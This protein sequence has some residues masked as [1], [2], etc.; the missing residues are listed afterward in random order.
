[1]A[2]NYDLNSINKLDFFS[3]VR[4]YPGMYIGSKDI[5]GLHHLV[6]EAVSNSI[7]E[8][9][10]GSCETI[11][12]IIHK[13]GSI[14]IIDNGRGIPIGK[15]EGSTKTALD[16]C[17]TEEHAGGKF[18]NATG[19]SGY[20][21][22]GGM[23]GLGTK[24]INALSDKMIV[25]SKRDN[26][27]EK[28]VYVKG[29]AKEHTIEKGT[30]HGVA[31][32][33]YPSKDY[34][35]TIEFDASII[36]KMIKEFSFLCKN[37]NFIFTDERTNETVNY[38][39]Q[40]GLYDFIEYLNKDNQFICDPFYFEEQEGTFKIEAAFGYN[41]SY[42]PTVRLFTNNIPQ[43]RG[44]HLTGFK[45]AFTSTFNSFAREKGWLKESDT[46]L[47]GSDLEEGQLLVINFKMIDPVF[48]GQAKEELGSSEG[49]TYV[50]RFTTKALKELFAQREKEVKV[51]FN[52]AIKARKAREE[53][54][55]ARD[56]VRDITSKKD[57][58]KKFL[59]KP[60]KLVDCW[61]KDRLKCQLLI[62]EGDSA[63]NGL[64]DARD[65][66]FHAIIPIRGKIIAAY[67]NNPEKIFANQEVQSLIKA[68]DLEFDMKTQKLIYDTK[69]LRYGK[70]LLCA[71]ADPDGSS[72]RN[73]LIELFWWICPELITKGHLYTTMP[74]LFRITTK[75][76]EYI[77]LKDAAALEDYK[78]KHIGEKY[79]INRNK[80]LGEQDPDELYEA[81]LDEQ[82][83]NIAQLTVEDEQRTALL[84]ETLFG[85]SVPPRRA[86][87]LEHVDDL[88]EYNGLTGDTRDVQNETSDNFIDF[89]NEVNIQRAFADARDGLKPCQRAAL[90]EMYN[91][92][93]TSNKPHVKS[94]R[95]SGGTIAKWWPHS[96]ASI[97]DTFARMSQDWINN[98]PEV[99]WHG[100]NGSVQISGEAAAMRYTEARLSK[101]IEEGMLASINK[102][103]VPMVP[104]FDETAEWPEVFPAILPRLMINGCQG[105]G[106]T[107]ANVWL[108]HNFAEMADIIKTYINEGTIDYSAIAPDFPTGG[109]I[110]NQKDLPTIYQTG[111]G[112]V[113]LRGVA[114]IE[115]NKII[116]TELPYQVYVESF[117]ASVKELVTKEEIT[118]ISEIENRK[119]RS[120][121]K[122]V[123]KSIRIEI[124]CDESPAS[125]LKQ[126]YK[127]TDLQKIYSPNQIAL[128]GKTPTMLNLKQYLDIYI[129]HNYDCIKREYEF[130]RIKAKTRLEIVEGLLRALEDIDNIIALIKA[131]SSSADAAK[132]L[133]AKYDFTEAQA[134]AIVDMKLGRLANLE[135]IE[136]NKE[137]EDLINTITECDD[138]ITQD[139]R[140]SMIFMERLSNLVKK[141]GSSP[142]KTQLTHI[143]VKPEEKEIVN[144]IP[145]DVVVVATQT[146]FIKRVASSA[147][148]VQKRGGKGVKSKDDSLLDVIKTNTVDTIM[149]FTTKGKMYRCSV[150]DI[151]AA[152][153]AAKGTLM[154]TIINLEKDEKVIAITSL[155]RTSTPEFIIF[156]TKNGMIKKSYLSEYTAMKR[157]TGIAALKVK[158][159]DEV[160]K[161]IFQDK[162]DI[163]LISQK[164]MSI[165]FKTDNIAPIGRLTMGVKG[166][167]LA[168]NDYVVAAMSVHKETDQVAV[169]STK[170]YGKK[171][172]L[173]EITSQNR[174]GR[175]LIVY[176]PT[177][178][179]GNVV[180]AAMVSDEDLILLCGN[181]TTICFPAKE[182]SLLGRV[183]TGNVLIKDNII[184]SATKI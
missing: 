71:D 100:A 47:T 163:I 6:K 157:N 19:Q 137:K 133:I 13:D 165:R 46:N 48:K 174:G 179:T 25:E 8:Y 131:S 28:I 51:I 155:H 126:L 154:N 24:C 156:I 36:K 23:H 29:I 129:Q 182:I 91:E 56:S 115:K 103:S 35:E 44:T 4:K 65:A 18:L 118:G 86:Y 83:R 62:V 146:G 107:I 93:Y 147:F 171:I 63:A 149:F 2:G 123:D 106:S 45:T 138:I 14:S 140:K 34:L 38:C 110:I 150:D 92:G 109:I 178:I 72:I 164:G 64:I 102:K 42:V 80:G 141:Y 31:V 68:L 184:L 57:K 33:F 40:Y 128:V 10:N 99:D 160:V 89:S 53:A 94:A 117:I 16:M 61:S 1:M 183:P 161:I 151:P 69:R 170:G 50:Q 162:E 108:P 58:K 168:E 111:K 5:A 3:A 136:L 180:Y 15:K 105:I 9:L 55:K 148:K 82:K 181:K 97:Y 113:V 177:E 166:I 78:A 73:L 90:W 116:I 30:G 143:E 79:Q 76:N 26:Q 112:R 39:S 175:G 17:F 7:D 173:S 120:K 152:T 37:L 20:N 52:K 59:D 134:K 12:V 41:E 67:K 158:E 74:P 121:D 144:I 114:D 21:S 70:I 66:E 96:D 27:V 169:I 22:A 49:R 135:K 87:L 167:A 119:S 122:K 84:M 130:N 77:Y 172:A 176:K 98:V 159:D 139:V 60:T 11:T 88:E 43:E 81:L 101:V 132:N 145:E 125:V 127:K 85:P 54:K 75:K 104:N 95:I 153:D 142:R 32:Q 124:E